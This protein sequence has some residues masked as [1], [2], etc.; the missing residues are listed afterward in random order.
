MIDDET[1]VMNIRILIDPIY[2]QKPTK[3][4]V[5]VNQPRVRSTETNRKLS[6]GA[7]DG[8]TSINN[9]FPRFLLWAGCLLTGFERMRYPLIAGTIGECLRSCRSRPIRS[10]PYPKSRSRCSWSFTKSSSRFGTHPIDRFEIVWWPYSYH[11]SWSSFTD[12][13]RGRSIDIRWTR[14]RSE[15]YAERRL[16]S[17]RIL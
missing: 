16:S 1:E 11:S 17:W 5:H 2:S 3:V 7:L 9:V 6:G 15:T 10:N 13:W 12:C 4:H 8:L 14:C